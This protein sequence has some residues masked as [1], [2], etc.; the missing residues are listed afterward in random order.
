MKSPKGEEIAREIMS[1]HYHVG[2]TS[3]LTSMRDWAATN[4]VTLRILK[5][6]YQTLIDIG[7]FSHSIDHVG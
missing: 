2:S 4:N 5:V 1:A 3:A 6:H 7:C